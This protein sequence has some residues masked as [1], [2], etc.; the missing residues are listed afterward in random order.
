TSHAHA[1]AHGYR[2]IE[3]A[4]DDGLM[5]GIGDRNFDVKVNWSKEWA[6]QNYSRNI[7][8]KKDLIC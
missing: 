2:L 7:Q 8:V 6:H 1:H 5:G 3:A 4:R